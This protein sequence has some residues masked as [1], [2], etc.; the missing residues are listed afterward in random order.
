MRRIDFLIPPL[1]GE[2]RREAPGWGIATSEHTPTR[3]VSLATR[4]LRGRD[5]K[6]YSAAAT[7][8]IRHCA[9]S[10]RSAAGLIGLFK[11]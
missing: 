3:L 11:I 10:A 4:P 9:K 7:R 6:D 8:S 1:K 5:K 2:G